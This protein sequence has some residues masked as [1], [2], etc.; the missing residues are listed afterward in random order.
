MKVTVRAYILIGLILLQSFIVMFLTNRTIINL[1]GNVIVNFQYPYYM[2]I[3]INLLGVSAIICIFYILYF[4]RK[5]KEGIIKL[6]NSKEVIDALQGQK[7]DFINHLNLI[8]GMLQL[9]QS[10]KA[11][12]YIFKISQKVEGVFSISKIEN[13]EIAATLGRK[14]TIAESKGI[15][16]ELDISTSLENLYIDSM[17][18]C[19]VLFNLIDNAI[20]ELEDCKEEEKVLIIDI[21]EHEEECVILIGNSYPILSEK[22]YEK[23]FEKGY[24]TKEGDGHG[25]G[26]NIVK[27]IINKNKG[28]ITV[29]S[30][31]GVGTVFTIFL[32]TRKRVARCS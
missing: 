17:D 4:L 12:D 29:E 24:S 25:Y 8:A 26:L 21:A 3:V 32:P 23:I 19:T 9:E 31:E 6:N 18:I 15:K 7:H 5:E 10:K 22:M 11:L 20:Y 27:Q 13:I 16:V 28:R 2:G 1:M 30:Y 14:C